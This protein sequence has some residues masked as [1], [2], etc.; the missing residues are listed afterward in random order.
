[1]ISERKSSSEV[2]EKGA[3]QNESH[4]RLSSNGEISDM[5]PGTKRGLKSRH[6]KMIALGGTIGTGLFV[7][8]GLTLAKG[9][10]AFILVGYIL[11]S[12]LVYL[13]VSSLTQMAAYL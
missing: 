2:P 13:V 12:I 5:Q 11:M 1:M 6:A 3:M 10:P 9:G 8:S 7:S 4:S